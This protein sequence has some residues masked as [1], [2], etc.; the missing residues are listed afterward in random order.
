MRKL[1]QYSIILN[2]IGIVYD[3]KGQ[4]DNALISDT[5]EVKDRK[6]TSEVF[7]WGYGSREHKVQDQ[8]DNNTS[9]INTIEGQSA[10]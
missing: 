3:I 10:Y 4:I 1:I 8:I 9:V 6:T 7:V 2:Y 5:N